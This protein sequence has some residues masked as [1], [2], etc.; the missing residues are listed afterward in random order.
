MNHR[1]LTILAPSAM[2]LAASLLFVAC[3]AP[4]KVT[5]P[6]VTPKVETA[7]VVAADP[8]A[9]PTSPAATPEQTAWQI[10]V[11]I[12]CASGDATK[13][14]LWETWTEQ[15]CIQQP[16]NPSCTAG[17]TVRTLHA[18]NLARR[19]VKT[20]VPLS[21]E[22]QPMMTT[23]SAVGA[24]APL[25]PFVPGNLG[26]APTFCEEVFVNTAE[27][28]YVNAPAAGQSLTTLTGQNAY[29]TS[30]KTITFPAGAVEVKAD[31]M[32]ATALTAA[33]TFDCASPP[34]GLLTETINGACYAL[35]GM[36][37]SSKL[38]PNWL[39]ATFEP[40]NVNTNP[41]RCKPTLYS[42]CTDAWG[43]NPATSQGTDTALT[44]AV[45]SMMI[46]AKLPTALN[47]YRL[48][49]AQTDFTDA[50]VTGLG[51]SF[52]EFNAGVL[53]D[54]ASCIT[55]HNSARFDNSTTPPTPGD[56]APP[57]GSVNIGGPTPQPPNLVSEDFS[58]FLAF[59]PAK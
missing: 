27:L 55:C 45:A 56:G 44:P 24:L 31:W 34:P 29:V 32:P 51:S 47:N 4:P 1:T 40:Q 35:V 42:A 25:L 28:A 9:L 50:T 20:T 6:P 36:H 58:W 22:C 3:G 21:T 37:I 39:W 46:K 59:M 54:Q 43:S 57:K 18:S 38:Y 19:L 49:G 5:P 15:T 8:C 41:N 26:T 30:G 7:P 14:L 23:A 53:P 10:F 48:T 16:T 17:S 33:T 2:A 11:A 52:V 12:N 13:P